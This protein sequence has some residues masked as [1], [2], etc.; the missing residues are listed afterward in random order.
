MKITGIIIL[1]E[2]TNPSIQYKAHVYAMRK[3]ITEYFGTKSVIEHD[4][5]YPVI[6]LKCEVTQD[7]INL[8]EKKYDNIR[9]LAITGDKEKIDSM[10][11]S[12]I[13]I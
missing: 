1:V 11:D 3:V 2:C 6:A 9:L 10:S 7:D 5:D 13:N 8:L 4:E 12:I